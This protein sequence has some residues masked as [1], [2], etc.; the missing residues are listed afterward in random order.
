MQDKRQS[1]FSSLDKI[2]RK[3]NQCINPLETVVG[4]VIAIFWTISD[5]PGL[6]ELRHEALKVSKGT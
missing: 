4:E 2:K 5:P 3:D 1:V 6:R